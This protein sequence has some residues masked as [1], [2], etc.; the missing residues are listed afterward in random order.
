MDGK[1]MYSGDKQEQG[2]DRQTRASQE[3]LRHLETTSWSDEK[4]REV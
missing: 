1:A 2:L 4:L 3:A